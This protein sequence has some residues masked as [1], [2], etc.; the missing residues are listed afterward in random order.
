[1][2]N[3]NKENLIDL[4]WTKKGEFETNA[5]SCDFKLAEMFKIGVFDLDDF[6][7]G[8]FW[9]FWEIF[10]LES[11]FS[12]YETMHESPLWRGEKN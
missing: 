1:L 5:V 10:C 2:S 9:S 4:Y 11:M 8:H 6:V 12:R 7:S 3:K